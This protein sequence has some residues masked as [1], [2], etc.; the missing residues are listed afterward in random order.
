MNT[1]Y[2]NGTLDSRLQA[3]MRNSCGRPRSGRIVAISRST[4]QKWKSHFQKYGT[5]APL[6]TQAK[7]TRILPWHAFV[8]NALKNNPQGKTKVSIYEAMREVLEDPPSEDQFLR[9][10]RTLSKGDIIKGRWNGMQL[11]NKQKYT[12]R[13]YSGL[14]P[15]DELH[16]DGWTT[17]FT[18]P[19]PVTGEYVTYEL[20]D[21]H[22]CATRYVPPMSVGMRENFEVIFKAIENAVR[23]GG[24]PAIL[25]TDSTKIV[26]AGE[27]FKNNPATALED[28]LGMTIVHPAK[29]GDADANGIAENF[30][31]YLDREARL[32][33]TYQHPDRMDRRTFKQVQKASKAVT[34]AREAG[35]LDAIKKAETHLARVGAGVLMRSLDDL[36]AWV[37][38]VRTK[39]NNHPHRKLKKVRDP[40]TGRLRHQ[41][42]QEALDEHKANGWEPV[43][44][45][46][47]ELLDAFRPHVQK[48]VTRGVV[49]P[50][51]GMRY[52]HADL[53]HYEG[54]SVVIAYD[55]DDWKHV[56][57]K[58]MKGK[59]ICVA[60]FDAAVDGRAKSSREDAEE[61]RALSQIKR[62]EKQIQAIKDRVPGEL[63][64][65][66][67]ERLPDITD[68]LPAEAPAERER[69]LTILDFLPAEEPEQ[70][71]EQTIL[72]FLP[73]EE[74]ERE[75]TYA[76][77]V[78]MLWGK[79]AEDTDG[80]QKE[81]AG[82]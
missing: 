82:Q 28:R 69:E 4:Y 42:P 55:I 39:W 37:E 65:I 67:A 17:H 14:K 59:T 10:I 16:A 56:V 52:Y 7:D 29:V 54:E 78:M 35:D 50:Y 38:T 60:E 30:H 18:A 77:T 33:A 26:K 81:T 66:P 32:L 40:K 34:K 64:D 8:V 63:I 3:A 6:I 9:F 22:D 25:Q 19:H 51:G 57:V 76:E 74:P 43:E 1:S 15:W 24:V 11:W 73:D 44:L 41:T 79:D 61:K 5:F 80:E 48:R 58:D 46:N 62:R 13:D 68:F 71:R 53:W 49:T 20:W 47:Q 2:A 75:P 36:M 27:R 23:F 70:E 72:D 31:T 12:V 21:V 45:N